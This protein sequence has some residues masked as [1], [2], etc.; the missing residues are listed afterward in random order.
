MSIEKLAATAQS[1][2]LPLRSRFRSTDIRY[3]AIFEGPSGW[4]EF[5]PF[6][7]YS[8]HIA[9]RWLA[10]ALEQACD[11]WPQVLRHEIP[12]NAIIPILDID[13]TIAAVTRAVTEFGMTTIKLKV[14][15]GQPN[16]H[17][18][19][20][21]RVASVRKT[22]HELGINGRIRIDING[23]WTPQDAAHRLR[24]LDDAAVGLDY[25]E[26]PCSSVHELAQLRELISDTHIKI[27]V[28]ESIRL[29]D[30]LDG[31]VL[32]EVADIAII[33]S[34]PIGGVRAALD[35]AERVGLPVV[36]SGSLDT[37][38][39]LASG[40]ALAGSVPALYGACGLGTGLLFAQDV[41][42]NP[43]VPSN[44]LLS[45]QRSAPDLPLH[46]TPDLDD[47]W[48]HR[49]IRAWHASAIHLVT[50]SVRE[51]VESW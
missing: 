40:L 2:A 41:T 11:S 6:P 9:G 47:E 43:L 38:I 36:V 22:L 48:Q 49:I 4:A 23:A 46:G 42:E 19:D 30:E 8:D 16:S 45:V 7:E 28:D 27:A 20:V 26:Q 29:S 32:R 35:V 3:G 12:I 25:V 39:G 44:G 51:A 34:L 31:H 15:D 10:G 33:K 24:E 17:D 5:A 14:D 50:S 18:R 13:Q 1:F 21:A 37:S